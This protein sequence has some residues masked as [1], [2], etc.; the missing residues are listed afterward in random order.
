MT[1]EQIKDEDISLFKLKHHIE[2]AVDDYNRRLK[3]L[4]KARPSRFARS[5]SSKFDAGTEGVEG[6]VLVRVLLDKI[7]IE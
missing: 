4:D 5:S 1:P 2:C 6:I 7:Q 3:K